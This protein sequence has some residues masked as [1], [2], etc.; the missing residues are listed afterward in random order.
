M[1]HP[2][3]ALLLAATWRVLQIRKYSVCTFPQTSSFVSVSL[4]GY[5]AITDWNDSPNRSA[6][7]AA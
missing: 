2:S 5:L 4:G 7:S 6:T 3:L 1:K